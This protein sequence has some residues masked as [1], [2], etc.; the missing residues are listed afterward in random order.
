MLKKIFSLILIFLF[1]IIVTL[2]QIDIIHYDI[3]LKIN[4]HEEN[5]NGYTTL[6]LTTSSNQDSIN[7]LLWKLTIDSIL[8]RNN[9][10][11]YKQD[12]QAFVI[13]YPLKVKDTVKITVYYHG[14]PLED[15]FWGGFYFK[16][17][18]AF[19]YGI[20]MSSYPLSVGRTWF[21]TNDLFTDK[22]Y[23]DFHITSPIQTKAVCNGILMDSTKKDNYITWHWHLKEPIPP[24]LA[25]VAVGKYQKVEWMYNNGINEKIPVEIYLLESVP[26]NFVHSFDNLDKVMLLYES[27]L[28]QY[29]WEKIGYIQTLMQSGAMEH[30]T[31][32]SMPY[33]SINGTKDNEKLIFHELAHSWFGNY[34]TCKTYKDMW[35]NEGWAEY[36]SFVAFMIYGYD[37]FEKELLY[38]HLIALN[39]AHINDNGYYAIGKINIENTYGTTIYKKGAVVVHNLRY[40]IGDSLFWQAVRFL[41]NKFAWKNVSI[42]D[43]QKTFEQ[44]TGLDLEDFFNFWIYSP[45]YP[46]FYVDNYSV[47]KQ[48]SGYQVIVKITQRLIGTDEY[49]KNQRIQIAFLKDKKHLVVKETFSQGRNTIDTFLLDFEPILIFLDPNQHLLDASTD[50]YYWIDTAGQYWFDYQFFDFEIPDVD[51]N[52]FLR[53]KINWLSPEQTLIN[54]NRFLLNSTYYWTI[55]LT[56]NKAQGK[57]KFYLS[58]LLDVNFK[59]LNEKQLHALR[60]FYRP[61]AKSEWKIID[62]NLSEDYQYLLT[63][64]L[65]SGDYIIGLDRTKL[66]TN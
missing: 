33:Y 58:S 17:N 22:A 55:Q 25:N 15:K 35:I 24:Y 45:G 31:N 40:Q 19:N 42:T 53:V 51:K 20:G 3:S 10:I 6:V 62:S 56:H 65:Q 37:A 28:G 52:F 13:F 23:F 7:L 48:K 14:K 4:P 66:K 60:L 16:N 54:N 5:I 11:N 46:F 18:Y 38:S 36:L 44:F 9:K 43:L 2:S 63:N 61:N 34:I 50:K 41:L 21:P 49:L 30:A 29:K 1:S 39:F 47:K 32:I 27:L 59:Q 8:I 57:A 12:E 64:Y 26:T